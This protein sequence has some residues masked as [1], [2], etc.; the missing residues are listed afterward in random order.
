MN[1][2]SV[3]AVEI[4]RRNEAEMVYLVRTVCDQLHRLE[5][6]VGRT[7]VVPVPAQGGAASEPF[8]YFPEP[9]DSVR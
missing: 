6:L 9:I 3:F 1:D 7:V 2:T 8:A 5:A 4:T